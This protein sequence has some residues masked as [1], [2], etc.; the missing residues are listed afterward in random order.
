[1]YSQ[2]SSYSINHSL[3]TQD[4]EKQNSILQNF[5]SYKLHLNKTNGQIIKQNLVCIRVLNA[6]PNT[7]KLDV[8]INGS[9][10]I[11]KLEYKHFTQYFTL[12]SGEQFI[13]IYDSDDTTKSIFCEKKLI[14]ANQYYTFA[15][16]LNDD[17]VSLLSYSDHTFL[18]LGEAKIRFINLTANAPNLDFAV[19]AGEGD[20]V[21]PNVAYE[22]ASDYLS[23]S[24]M[25]VNLEL[26]KPGSKMIIL[27]LYKTKF[28]E[29]KLY[30]FVSV[31]LIDGD[32]KIEVITL[33]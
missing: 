4:S 28:E 3:S 29:N 12:L 21:F 24:P 26:R 11:S 9:K 27:P 19:K 22:S 15:V 17:T 20:V 5:L 23:L 18:P 32:P 14:Q 13:E 10:L 31:G 1:M 7:K 6:L 33:N 16:G 25:T 8:F 2:F 30:T